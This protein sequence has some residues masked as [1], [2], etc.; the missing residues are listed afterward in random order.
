MQRLAKKGRTELVE[1]NGVK[2]QLHR[3]VKRKILG[4]ATR[5]I[6]TLAPLFI[7]AA[8]GAETNRRSTRNI[9]DAVAHDLAL[10]DKN[11]PK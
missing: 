1:A 7:G 9:G 5:N 10:R 8:I 4:R 2:A 3:V 6:G 11:T